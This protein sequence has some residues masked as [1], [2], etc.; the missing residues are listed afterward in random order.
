MMP[1]KQ[2]ALPNEAQPRVTRTLMTLALC[3]ALGVVCLL[4]TSRCV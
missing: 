1:E 2:S 4:Y 3:Y